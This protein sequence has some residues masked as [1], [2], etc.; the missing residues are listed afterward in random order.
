MGPQRRGELVMH[1]NG[2]AGHHALSADMTATG[3]IYAANEIKLQQFERNL[4]LARFMQPVA[5][6]R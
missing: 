5:P 2:G 3:V 6:S 4:G 1:G